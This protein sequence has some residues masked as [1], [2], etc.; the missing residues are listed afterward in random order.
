MTEIDG[1]AFN[2]CDDLKSIKLPASLTS[3][4][5][6]AFNCCYALKRVH[7]AD[8][9]A[10][11]KVEF[12]DVDSNPIA[13]TTELYLGEELLTDL[14]IPEGVEHIAAYA[15]TGNHGGHEFESVTIP[16]SLKSV[17][18]EAFLYTTINNI[19]ITD[20]VSWCMIDFTDA[21]SVPNTYYYAP[22][23][24]INGEPT[25]E[26]VIP[27]GIT[28]IKDYAFYGMRGI[29]S[30]IFGDDVVSIGKQAFYQCR[31]ERLETCS[32]TT[33]GDEAFY[34]CIILDLHIGASLENIG[35]R[36]LAC[37]NYWNISVDPNNEFFT[38]LDGFLYTKDET[39]LL[40]V[41]DNGIVAPRYIPDGTTTIGAYAFSGSYC[42]TT[43][44]FPDSV[45]TIGDDAFRY[46]NNIESITLPEG[47]THVGNYAFYWCQSLTSV[48]LPD[49]ILQIGDY[50][51]S[52]C[53]NLTDINLP[54]GLEKI[55]EGAFEGTGLVSIAIPDSVVSVGNSA[56]SSCENLVSA[57]LGSGMSN[58]QFLMFSYC[59]ALESVYIPESITYIEAGAFQHCTA[60]TEFI[61]PDTVTGIGGSV[62]YEC[63]SLV[64]V[65]L[66]ASLTSMGGNDFDYCTSLTSIVIPKG[67]TDISYATFRGCTA[68]VSIVFEDPNGWGAYTNPII[69]H[70]TPI[71]VS[72][73]ANAA[74]LL[75]GQYCEYYV[76]K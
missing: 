65:T 42:F 33:I 16:R 69:V 35:Y 38:E 75:T 5:E 57:T 10:W 7:I 21:G 67:V 56:F 60:L 9:A 22:T 48:V 73:P 4:G 3:I 27:D 6:R 40:L 64:S 28:E 72:D 15:F 24:Y 54:N 34:E 8:V 25:T 74:A 20:L 31:L 61:M 41:A 26:L 53:R 59:T 71:D 14:V 62:F 30:V 55:G 39:T 49:S 63:S 36:A 32:V 68:L 18:T 17:G 52:Q 44:I 76:H 13:F 12:A 29:R 51:F 11:C 70:G 66:S 50:A 58:I 45:T 23:V 2:F 43:V 19:H 46:C 37:N 47:L 1:D